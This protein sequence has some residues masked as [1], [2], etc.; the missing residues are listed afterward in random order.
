MAVAPPAAVA[1][2][3]EE[4]LD[5]PAPFDE[6]LVETEALPEPV[7]QNVFTDIPQ[8]V[9]GWNWHKERSRRSPHKPYVIHI[10]EVD[11][12]EQYA[13][14]TLTYFA[15]D[16][17]L[18]DETDDILDKADRDRL[19]GEQNLNK[20]G[21][22]SRDDAVVYIRNDHLETVFDVNLSDQSYSMAVRGIPTETDELRHS[23]RRRERSFDDE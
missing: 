12:M 5:D 15:E 23:D 20:F 11:E 18:C 9:D 14:T 7:E 2:A 6:E 21:H 17:V 13:R 10:D 19:I 22:G 3:A 4:E 16:D 8:T 1:E